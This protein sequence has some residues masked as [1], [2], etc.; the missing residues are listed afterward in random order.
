MKKET[1]KKAA[2]KV[3]KKSTF[4]IMEEAKAYAIKKNPKQRLF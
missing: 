4:I 1:I 3:V 2:K